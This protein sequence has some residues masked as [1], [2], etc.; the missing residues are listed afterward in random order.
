VLGQGSTKRIREGATRNSHRAAHALGGRSPVSRRELGSI[1]TLILSEGVS[2]ALSFAYYIAAARLLAPAGFGIVRYTITLSLLAF[3]VM[4]VLVTVLGRELGASRGDDHRMSAVIGT[5][6]ALAVA[7]WLVSMLAC[8]AAIV[9]QVTG[10][11]NAVGLLAVLSGYAVFQI[12]YAISWGLGRVRRMA[13]TYAGGGALQL[14]ALL[15]IA[16]V[17]HPGPAVALVLFGVSNLIPIALLEAIRPVIRGQALRVDSDTARRLARVGLPLLAAQVGYVVWASA[18]QIWVQRSLGSRQSGLYGAA[19]NL[20]QLFLILPAGVNG[21]LM[22]R[23]AELRSRGDDL[24]ARRMILGAT[25]G[26]VVCSAIAALL[27]VA[28][29]TRLL[30]LLYGDAYSAG[31]AAL[32]V[33]C[34]AMAIYAGFGTLTYSIVGWGRPGVYTTAIAV[35]AA[36]E[37]TYLGTVTATSPTQ[38]AWASAASIAAGCVAALVHLHLARHPVV[39]RSNMQRHLIDTAVARARR[40]AGLAVHLPMLPVAI[41]RLRRAR[42]RA[43]R[44]EELVDLAYSFNVAGIRI[45]PW[46]VRSELEAWLQ[47]VRERKPRVVV[48]IGTSSGGT[49][50]L[51]AAAAAPDAR[52][53]S[54]DLPSGSFGGGYAWWR[55]WLYR[56]FAA[57]GQHIELLRADSHDVRVANRL[58]KLLGGE[59]IDLL[60]IDGDHSYDGVRA[61]FET[62]SGLVARDGLV[63]FHDIVPGAVRA[64]PVPARNEL[65]PD[66][67]EVPRFWN[68]IS[69]RFHA[70]EIVADAGQG[71]YGIGILEGVGRRT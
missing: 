17:I 55:S 15:A 14:S 35:A 39:R 42:A 3:G 60:F 51:L 34:V 69:E 26:V 27:A 38:A 24:R 21:V 16:A 28:L 22:P 58:R 56:S 18:D 71:G 36:V 47:V 59:P 40:I 8:A 31:A 2:R 44:P 54:I 68:Q 64:D 1:A 45:N 43:T 11:A 52:L 62:Y 67:G 6:I 49:L 7:G 50:F 32:A 57:Q 4:Q 30:V 61:D 37:V 20:S 29:R 53:V 19:K 63:T 41:V 33:L 23:I 46:Q 5:S 12:Y 48:E 9:F 65:G 66:P 70:R 13:I 10:K 25:A